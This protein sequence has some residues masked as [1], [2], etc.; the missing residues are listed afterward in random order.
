MKTAP[1]NLLIGLA[2]VFLAG[3]GGLGYMISKASGEYSEARTAY[4]RKSATYNRLRGLSLFP[5]QANLDKLEEQ[6]EVATQS[7]E[8]LRKKLE[9]MSFPLETI[10]PEQFQ[11]RL[12]ATVSAVSE[13]ALDAG[14][15][16]PDKF[17]LGFD[18]YQSQPPK[19]EAAAP[20]WRQLKAIELVV[21]TLIE[22]NINALDSIQRTALPEE[23]G[24][25]SQ[26]GLVSAFPFE[27]QFTADQGHFRKVLNEIVGNQK[28]F[29]IARS[30]I[31]KNEHDKPTPRASAQGGASGEA[32]QEG[33]ASKEAALQYI[34]G[35][36][37]INATLR[38]EMVVFANTFP[39]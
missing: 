7:A 6:K 4:E 28:Q 23:G 30:I 31:V 36:E 2:V 21:T 25:A 33:G 3:A 12:R 5:N 37:K 19:A 9:P 38:L 1:N 34:V 29:F 24:K 13:K 15:K 17:Y 18:Q 32:A 39:K 27:I 11:D 14:M 20:L 35:T 26:A 10:T 22:G 16:I 8:A